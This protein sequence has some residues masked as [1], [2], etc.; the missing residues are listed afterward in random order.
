[1]PHDPNPDYYELLGVAPDATTAEIKAAYRD[2][3]KAAHPDRGGS[4]GLF[5]LLRIAHDTLSDPARR[6]A[7]DRTRHDPGAAQD[8]LTTV[9]DLL[10][11]PVAEAVAALALRGFVPH[12]RTSFAVPA[13]RQMAGLVIA[14]DPS[15][16]TTAAV[17]ASVA[18]M[19]AAP[20]DRDGT[21]PGRPRTQPGRTTSQADATRPP[22]TGRQPAPSGGRRP[23]GSYLAVFLTV[24][25]LALAGTLAL[26]H[27]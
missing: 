13:T 27:G 26:L 19:V 18:L 17:G 25:A 6:V 20:G 10:G 23:L 2:R 7:Y 21:S 9:P 14:Q 22:G 16:G 11:R 3:A 12:A 8:P 5:R 24:W 1:M 15:P 4:A